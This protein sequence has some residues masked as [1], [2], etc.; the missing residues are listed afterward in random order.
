[1]EL[2]PKTAETKGLFGMAPTLGGAAPLK[3]L[4]RADSTPKLQTQIRVFG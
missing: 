2:Y 3:T 4:T 1:M